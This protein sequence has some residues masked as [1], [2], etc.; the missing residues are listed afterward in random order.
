MGKI[1]AKKSKQLHIAYI[2]AH[3]DDAEIKFGGT[4]IKYLNHGH[5]ITFV[6]LT[7]GDAG[8][9][10]LTRKK[11]AARRL[12]EAQAVSHAFGIDYV[13]WDQHDGELEASIANRTRL[14]SLIRELKPNMI[15]TH[16]DCDYHADHRATA[17]L[18]LD[19]AYLVAVPSISPNAQALDYNPVIVHH[20]DKFVKPQS[21]NPNITVDISNVIDKKME[22]ISL[23]ESQ[24]YE[25][26]P[27]IEGYYKDA[28]ELD[29]SKPNEV[30][31]FLK[32]RCGYPTKSMPFY[33][34][35]ESVIGKGNVPKHTE[36]FEISEYGGELNKNNLKDFFPFGISLL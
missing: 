26:L 25:W 19:S 11:L 35:I 30:N 34:K 4:A 15:V 7:N 13:I 29:R 5:K 18:V 24:L 12:K 16:R 22:M 8:H 31:A 1:P 20:Q 27:W 9:Q 10:K 3:P 2:G 33:E 23:H 17:R 21:F 36:S 32:K 14:I 28:K 6:S